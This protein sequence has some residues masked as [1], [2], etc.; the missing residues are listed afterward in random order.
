MDF[1]LLF[2]MSVLHCMLQT[3]QGNGNGVAINVID[4]IVITILLEIYLVL[5]FFQLF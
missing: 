1:T 4:I 2:I 3:T 5:W